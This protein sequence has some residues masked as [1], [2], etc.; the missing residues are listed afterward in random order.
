MRRVGRRTRLRGNTAS[1][2]QRNSGQRANIQLPAVCQIVGY[3]NS[4]KT[5]LICAVIPLLKQRGYS[6][7]VIKHDAHTY[8]MDHHGTDTWKQRQAGAAAVAITNNT[9]TSVIKERSSSLSE[10]IADFSGYDY[11]IV[12]GFKQEAYPKIVLL[13]S[14]EDRSLL[15]QVSNIAA[16]AVWETME[17]VAIAENWHDKLFS[18]NDSEG[19]ANLLWEQRSSFQN[20]N[21]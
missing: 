6:V 11:V 4:G 17:Q 8:D 19:I 10:L 13:H 5:T 7:A 9:R 12:E 3:K 14:D 2:G 1:T 16:I 21:I 15:N 18:I 20:F